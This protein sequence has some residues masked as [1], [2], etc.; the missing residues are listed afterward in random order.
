M[1]TRILEVEYGVGL[2]ELIEWA[3]K[4]CRLEASVPIRGIKIE[5]R[6]HM[7]TTVILDVFA[8]VPEKQKVVSNCQCAQCGWRDDPNAIPSHV[9]VS[10]ER[11][12]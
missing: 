10:T 2:K 5:A 9:C 4:F 11:K 8:V 1:S 12:V 6:Y 7:P 3:N